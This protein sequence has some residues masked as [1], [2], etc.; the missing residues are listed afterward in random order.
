M[1]ISSENYGQMLSKVYESIEQ[2]EQIAN[3]KIRDAF[4]KIKD[5]FL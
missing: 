1:S 3:N 2:G 4:C 5:E